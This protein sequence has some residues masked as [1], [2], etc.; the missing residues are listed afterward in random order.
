MCK[1]A[2]FRSLYPV[3]RT[4]ALK[5]MPAASKPAPRS[6]LPGML[7]EKNPPFVVCHLFV[8]LCA[9]PQKPPKLGVPKDDK[10]SVSGMHNRY[11]DEHKR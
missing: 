2:G 11:K 9:E 6:A 4:A 8:T 7:S 5:Q 10:S 3:A 1:Q